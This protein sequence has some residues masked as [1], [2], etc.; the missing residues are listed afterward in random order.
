MKKPVS[1]NKLALK[2]GIM[3][4]VTFAIIMALFDLFEDEPFSILKFVLHILLFGV[5][6][7]LLN[8]Y[9]LKKNLDNN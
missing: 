2:V 4:G 6:M 3:S 9:K 1:I 5:F 7:G 8:R